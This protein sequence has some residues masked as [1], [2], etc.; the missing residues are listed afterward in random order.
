MTARVLVNSVAIAELKKKNFLFY[1]VVQLNNNIVLVSSL[2]QSDS[3]IHAHASILYAAQS[4]RD[5]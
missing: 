3:V 1:A 5:L 4:F 2:Q